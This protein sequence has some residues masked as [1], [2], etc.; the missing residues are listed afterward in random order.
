MKSFRGIKK[1]K[2]SVSESYSNSEIPD[3]G[4]WDLEMNDIEVDVIALIMKIC[5]KKQLV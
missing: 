1:F 2:P 4:N 3:I 5:W